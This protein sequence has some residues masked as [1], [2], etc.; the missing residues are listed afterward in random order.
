MNINRM[1]TWQL[2]DRNVFVYGK[3]NTQ[4]EDKL[5]PL[6]E[7]IVAGKLEPA[8]EVTRQAI[9]AGVLPK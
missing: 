7:A 4:E 1:P 6:Y 8:V 5:K 3:N 2:P 9:A